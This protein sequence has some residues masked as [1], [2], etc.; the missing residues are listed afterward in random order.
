MHYSFLETNL[1]VYFLV[2]TVPTYPKQKMRHYDTEEVKVGNNYLNNVG[3][4][5][6]NIHKGF[7]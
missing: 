1:L 6:L 2:P 7:L 3:V 5:V 4:N